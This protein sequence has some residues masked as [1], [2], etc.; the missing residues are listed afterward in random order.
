MEDESDSIPDLHI[1]LQTE[2]HGDGGRY[3]WSGWGFDLTLYLPRY[4][5]EHVRTASRPAGNVTFVIRPSNSGSG[6]IPCAFRSER[7]ERRDGKIMEF[8]FD[9]QK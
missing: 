5:T 6:S 1:L 3:R 8:K 2:I 9:Y 4:F 7:E